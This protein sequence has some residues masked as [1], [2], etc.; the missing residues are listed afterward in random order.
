MYQFSRSI[1][2]EVADEVLGADDAEVASNRGHVPRECERT[3]ER[4]GSDSG[5]FASRP[6]RSSGASA[7]ISR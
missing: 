7:S 4:L 5:Y 1:F 6:A 2:R 3:M